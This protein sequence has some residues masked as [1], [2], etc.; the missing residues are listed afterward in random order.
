MKQTDLQLHW[1]SK[2]RGGNLRSV[3]NHRTPGGGGGG[4]AS[5]LFSTERSNGAQL[6]V[7]VGGGGRRIKGAHR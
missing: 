6:V 4:V 3:K 1:V 2:D 5:Y 7:Q